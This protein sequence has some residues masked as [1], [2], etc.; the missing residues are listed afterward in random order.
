MISLAIARYLSLVNKYVCRY[1]LACVKEWHQS[2]NSNYLGYILCLVFVFLRQ[3]LCRHD[4]LRT[5]FVDQGGLELTETLF[6]LDSRGLGLMVS[7]INGVQQVYST[8][9]SQVFPHLVLSR[10]DLG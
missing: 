8:Q 3:G 2:T 4:V 9:A 10:P 1:I 5:H 6:A 7:A